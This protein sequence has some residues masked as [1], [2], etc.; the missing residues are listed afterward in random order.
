VGGAAS[1]KSAKALELAGTGTPRTFLATGQPLDDEMARRIRRHRMAR[2][3][4]WDTAEVPVD[5]TDWFVKQ[6]P[7]YRVIILDCL[8]LWLSNLREQGVPDTQVSRLTETLLQAMRSTNG[9]IVIVTNELGMGLVPMDAS[10]RGFRDL[11][12]SV[13]Q[14]VAQEAD[15]VHL[16]VSGLA[17]RLK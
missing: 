10:A 13:N 17:V 2:G 12:G 4:G 1:G 9:R 7:R 6:G 8:T 14:Q 16:V 15:E 5:L 11:A 3:P